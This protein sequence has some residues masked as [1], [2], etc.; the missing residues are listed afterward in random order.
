MANRFIEIICP[1]EGKACSWETEVRGFVKSLHGDVVQTMVQAAD[2]R[3]YPQPKV[4]RDRHLFTGTVFLG[5]ETDPQAPTYK[6]AAGVGGEKIPDVMDQLPT[7][8]LWSI[9][10]VKRV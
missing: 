4:V 8:T 5:W 3:W 6:I 10:T 1:A 7:D 9:I 2:M